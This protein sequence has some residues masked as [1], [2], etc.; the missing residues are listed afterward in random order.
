MNKIAGKNKMNKIVSKN[1]GII[2]AAWVLLSTTFIIYLPVKVSAGSYDGEDLALAILANHAAVSIRQ[3][4]LRRE[5]KRK[6][7]ELEAA[8]KELI[9]ADRLKAE[10]ISAVTSQMRVP[11]DAIRAYSQ[12]VLQRMDDNSFML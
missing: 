8:H 11:L 4:R 2:I 10:F 12:T 9:G 6:L 1:L 3:T 7:E 5:L